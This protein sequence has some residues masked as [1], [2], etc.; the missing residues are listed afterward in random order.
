MQL[1]MCSTKTDFMD[2]AKVADDVGDG[3]GALAV[4]EG[5]GALAVPKSQAHVECRQYHFIPWPIIY[6]WRSTQPQTAELLPPEAQ[7]E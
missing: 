6:I 7:F 2:E 3:E 1:A 5:E 4:S